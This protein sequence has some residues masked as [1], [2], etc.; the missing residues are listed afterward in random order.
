[1]RPPPVAGLGGAPSKNVFFFPART[2]QLATDDGRPL[3]EGRKNVFFFPAGTAQGSDRRRS[4]GLGREQNCFL[5]LAGVGL[6]GE[7]AFTVHPGL[8]PP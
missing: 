2:A 4:L 3:W 5:F 6:T 8:C 7:D 1:M